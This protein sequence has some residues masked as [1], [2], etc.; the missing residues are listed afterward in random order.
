MRPYRIFTVVIPTVLIHLSGIAEAGCS[1]GDPA[2]IPQAAAMS[3]LLAPVAQK[4]TASETL[5]TTEPPPRD[6][7]SVEKAFVHRPELE[8]GPPV[9]IDY[10]TPQ[11]LRAAQAE[12][13]AKW[14]AVRSVRAKVL[15]KYHQRKGLKYRSR[16]KGTYDC[17]KRGDQT[18]FL[19]YRFDGINAERAKDDKV[20][21]GERIL[22]VYD[23]DFLYFLDEFHN[24][25]TA[26][27]YASPHRVQPIGGKQLFDQIHRF[28]RVVRLPDETINGK[29][30]YVFEGTNHSNRDHGLYYLDVETGIL[31]KMVLEN[32]AMESERTLILDDFKLNYAFPDNHF[33][34]V[35]PEGVALTDYTRS[36]SSR[37]KP[38]QVKPAQ[39]P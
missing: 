23:G 25:K 13:L 10:S 26:Y 5:P 37:V 20:K 22:Y 29:Y 3:A 11:A 24:S 9:P 31:I 30:V 35:L 18:L 34:F 15:N 17:M 21:T 38:V 7:A 4:P 12:L 32:E 8:M 1:H 19:L 14:D 39:A 6:D 2:P 28:D 16:G 33:I 36:T 27:K